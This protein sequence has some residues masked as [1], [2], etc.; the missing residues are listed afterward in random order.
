[1]QIEVWVLMTGQIIIGEVHPTLGSTLKR[2]FEIQ[3]DPNTQPGMQ[4][5]MAFVEVMQTMFSEEDHLTL[6]GNHVI[7]TSYE[8]VI[9]LRNE[10]AKMVGGIMESATPS[11]IVPGA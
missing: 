8:P 10:Y 9:Q 5:K 1:M 3:L 6:E 4:P 11:L 2:P 7:M